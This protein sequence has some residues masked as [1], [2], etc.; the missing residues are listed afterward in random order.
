MESRTRYG[1]PPGQA[2]GTLL[3]L[4]GRDALALLHRIWQLLL[5]GHDEVARAAHPG[6]AADMALLRLVHASQLPDPGDLAKKL[7]AG[8][9]IAVPGVASPA[10]GAGSTSALLSIPAD[11]PGLIN[12]LET[13][14]KP[15]LGQQ[16]H[17]FAGLVRYAP[18]ELVL[19]A[20]KPLPADFSR[21]MAAALKSLTGASWTIGLTEDVAAPS[22]LDQD[23]QRE[24]EA[25]N[26]IL[27]D[28]VIKAA[29]DA[30]PDAELIDF[31]REDQR[32]LIA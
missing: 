3:R 21:D 4:E 14:G 10:S 28:P 25:R 27:S 6:E 32:S 8:E 2:T 1:T 5:K 16:L 22:L 11:F 29:F 24:N 9:A 19:K 17:D 15:H 31:D 13:N 23:R 12:L 18:P 7:E 30:F 20:I 26:A